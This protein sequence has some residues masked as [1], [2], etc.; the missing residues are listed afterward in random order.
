MLAHAPA[1]IHNVLFDQCMA[2]G[3]I[4]IDMYV[5]IHAH[6]KS[7]PD[8]L[9]SNVD[10]SRLIETVPYSYSLF[11]WGEMSST[12]DR[13]EH[14]YHKSPCTN[15]YSLSRCARCDALQQRN[16]N[17]LWITYCMLFQITDE[18]PDLRMPLL[19]NLKPEW[20]VTHRELDTED[21][22]EYFLYTCTKK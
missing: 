1:N 13:T 17:G 6:T 10:W 12:R 22:F 15:T 8:M 18:V 7:L 3:L 2:A 20:E 14:K 19:E 5:F 4:E 11:F 16:S 9:L 21:G